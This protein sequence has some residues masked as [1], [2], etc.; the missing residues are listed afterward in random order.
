VGVYG[1]TVTTSGG[2]ID[3]LG[4]GGG[5]ATISGGSI[6]AL[7]LYGG[8]MS[9][10]GCDLQLAADGTLTGTLEYNAQPSTISTHGVTLAN[11]N[12]IST[13]AYGV[14]ALFAQSGSGKAY[15]QGSTIP[16]KL[17]LL[18]ANGSNASSSALVVHALGLTQIAGGSGTASVLDPG[19]SN[20]DSDF[21]YDATLQGYILNLSTK[22]LGAGTWQ[23]TFSVNGLT[24][25]SYA[26][27]FVL[28]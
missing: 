8:T 21:R 19:S 23:L 13:C 3:S 17:Q 27:T 16:V 20:P 12:L 10:Y 2:S 25:P 11:T 26:V 28:Q 24:D 4:L 6:G 14:N 1:G 22:N 9:V 7:F 5:T 18:G 15:K